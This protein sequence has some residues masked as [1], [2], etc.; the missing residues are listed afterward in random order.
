MKLVHEIIQTAVAAKTKAQKIKILQAN[1]TWALKDILRGTYDDAVKWNIPP[2][3]PPYTPNTIGSI[4]SSF[5]KKNS[6]LKYFVQG[7]PGDKLM[8]AKRE[9]LFIQLLES[10]HPLDAELV[11]QM[12]SK[13]K[14]T[15]LT[16][17]TVKE[18]FPDLITS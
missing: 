5:N 15:G 2:G 9:K 16:I 7:G 1:E 10:I 17:N 6:Q 18:A 11:I 13:N 14:I 8:K 12:I 3:T 4:P